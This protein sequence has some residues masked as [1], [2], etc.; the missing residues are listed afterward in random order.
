MRLKRPAATSRQQQRP[1]I[2]TMAIVHM[3]QVAIDQIIDMIT[4]LHFYTT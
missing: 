2:I 1:V 4:V 3:V